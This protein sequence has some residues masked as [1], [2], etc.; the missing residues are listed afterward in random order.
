MTDTSNDRI[1]VQLNYSLNHVNYVQAFSCNLSDV[2][3]ESTLN[4]SA[5]QLG[6]INNEIIYYY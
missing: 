5:Q 6:M 4:Y 1:P 3:D 2:K